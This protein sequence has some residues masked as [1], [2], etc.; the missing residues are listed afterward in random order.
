MN[1]V[2]RIR[3]AGVVVAAIA[4]AAAPAS[5]AD[6]LAGGVGSYMQQWIGY[7]DRI[8][9]GSKVFFQADRDGNKAEQSDESLAHVSSDA[10][11]WIEGA[12]PD[13][14]SWTVQVDRGATEFRSGTYSSMMGR[15]AE[16]YDGAACYGGGG[17]DCGPPPPPPPPPTSLAVV[18]DGAHCPPPCP[19]RCPCPCP[20]WHGHMGLAPDLPGWQSVDVNLPDTGIDEEADDSLTVSLG[21]AHDA[22]FGSA[23]SSI[24]SLGLADRWIDREVTASEFLDLDLGSSGLDVRAGGWGQ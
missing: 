17:P 18:F 7:A 5:A 14:G 15:A 21:G 24:Y 8:Q 2:I 22:S 13:T 9:S 12:D 19:P 3:V 20:P 4:V 10:L 1:R 6:M 23:V 16:A 11:K